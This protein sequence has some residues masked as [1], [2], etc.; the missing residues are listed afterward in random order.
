MGDALGILGLVAFS[1]SVLFFVGFYKPYSPA[2]SLIGVTL[3]TWLHG[4]R[5]SG[6]G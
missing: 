1:F 4:C 2:Y 6:H 3:S 5:A